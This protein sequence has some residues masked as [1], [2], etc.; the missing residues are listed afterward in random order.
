MWILHLPSTKTC[1]IFTVVLGDR[2]STAM[3]VR[4]Q[5]LWTESWCTSRQV[6]I[7]MGPLCVADMPASLG[8]DWNPLPLLSACPGISACKLI[9]QESE[10]KS[11]ASIV[12]AYLMPFSVPSERGLAC[13]LGVL[14]DTRSRNKKYTFLFS[15]SALSPHRAALCYPGL[16]WSIWESHR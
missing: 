4:L 3:K 14:T 7:I 6:T 15:G 8:I 10:S 2:P 16:V 1:T 11:E 13:A 5:S 9:L 12:L